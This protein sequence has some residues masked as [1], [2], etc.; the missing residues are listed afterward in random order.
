MTGKIIL[1]SFK[2]STFKTSD[3]KIRTNYNPTSDANGI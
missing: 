3:P 1:N 2:F